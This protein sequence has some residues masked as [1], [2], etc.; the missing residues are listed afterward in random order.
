MKK[1]TGKRIILFL[2]LSFVPM[3]GL[4]YIYYVTRK[5]TIL[6]IMMLLPAVASV[7]TRIITKEGLSGM[8]LHPNLKKNLKWY[9]VSYF[10]PPFIAYFGA[11]MYFFVF[12]SS[13]F[14]PLQ[15][16][17]AVEESI[18]STSELLK[19]LFTL[20]P[21]AIIINPIMGSVQC[22][23]EELGWR[24]YL[25]PK[26]TEKKSP[27]FASVFTGVIWGLWHA[28]I[29][30]MGYNYG[31]EHPIAGVF[32]MVVFC[33]VLGIILSYLTYKVHS[34]WPATLFHASINGMDT[35]APSTLFMSHKSN[36]F[37]GPDLLGV[38]GGIGFIIIDIALIMVMKKWKK[39]EL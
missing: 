10:A 17:F 20:I 22:F 33:T 35:W 14:T 37:L 11:M 9:F 7:M 16:A 30:A 26:L 27:L 15:S 18:S 28:P 21:L 39:V 4:S 12:K 1:E 38:I 29:I 24:G 3:W 23:D 36:V 5:D 32:A 19:A 31:T 25:L 34:I 2:L 8:M 6:L 13:D